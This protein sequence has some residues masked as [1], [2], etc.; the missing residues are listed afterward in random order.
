TVSYPAYNT[1]L[2]F[3]NVNNIFLGGIANQDWGGIFSYNLSFIILGK[4]DSSLNL[5][6]QKYYGGDMYYMVWSIIATTDGGCIIGASSNDLTTQGEERDVYILKVDSNG[7]VT[8]INNQPP[9]LTPEVIVYPNPGNDRIYV[10]TQLKNAI[11]FLYDLTGREV[12]HA[13]LLPVRNSIQVQNLKSGLYIYKLIQNS[14]VKE[15]GKWI[16]K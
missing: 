9:V 15:C 16:K 6:W 13:C 2:D 14:Q 11:F 7:I 12:L 3:L 8:G 1:N 10:E 5:T 4:I